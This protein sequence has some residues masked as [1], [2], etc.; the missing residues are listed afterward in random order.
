MPID[1]FQIGKT[2]AEIVIEHITDEIK[3]AKPF[4]DRLTNAFVDRRCIAAWDLLENLRLAAEQL[5]EDI[6]GDD[7]QSHWDC[8][9]RRVRQDIRANPLLGSWTICRCEVCRRETQELECA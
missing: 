5:A 6:V 3:A 2:S 4:V 8:E 9:P 1:T 7:P